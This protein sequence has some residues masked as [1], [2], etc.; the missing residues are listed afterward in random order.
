M[1]EIKAVDKKYVSGADEV[2]A[3]SQVSLSISNG[4][5]LSITGPSGAGKSTLLHI[6]GGLDKPLCGEVVYNDKQLHLMNDKELSSWRNKTVGFV[7][8]FYH[9]IEELNLVENVALPAINKPTKSSFKKARELLEYLG[10]DSH[11]RFYPSQLSGGQKQ[12]TAIARALI[13]DPEIILCDEPTG[14]LDQDSQAKVMELL[15]N[16]N[17]EK[18]KTIVMVTHNPELSKRAKK[19]VHIENG[20]ITNPA[21]GGI[22]SSISSEF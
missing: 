22:N 11:H 2:M 3:L 7:F 13:N 14:N 15:E 9:L 6:A 5:Y 17:K 8:Q 19:T 12:K 1:L 4:D 21:V 18:N 16:L 20:K 10:I